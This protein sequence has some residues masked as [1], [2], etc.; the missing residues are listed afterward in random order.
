MMD[1]ATMFAGVDLVYESSDEK[2]EYQQAAAHEF[3][4]NGQTLQMNV[5]RE[6]D[7]YDASG[8]CLETVKY[9][10]SVPQDANENTPSQVMELTAY[11]QYKKGHPDAKVTTS[12]QR[13]GGRESGIVALPKELGKAMYAALL[14]VV[15][16][17]IAEQYP[18]DMVHEVNEMRGISD[19]KQPLTHEQW[20]AIFGPILKQRHYNLEST[21]FYFTPGDAQGIDE[22]EWEDAT[23]WAKIYPGKN[24][25]LHGIDRFDFNG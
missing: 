18:V 22:D 15:L 21:D 9:A 23:R 11:V 17:R 19:S 4:Y 12:I 25:G 16:P 6:V 7:R 24:K 14:D 10:V 8:L 3:E 20:M 2:D 5:E 1:P 13:Y